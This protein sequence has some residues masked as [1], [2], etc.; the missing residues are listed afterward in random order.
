MKGDGKYSHHSNMKKSVL[1]F[2]IIILLMLCSSW[3]IKEKYCVKPAIFLW[4]AIMQ[5]DNRQYFI[6]GMYDDYGNGGYYCMNNNEKIP[7]SLI[8]RTP[9]SELSWHI[10][11]CEAGNQFLVKGSISSELSDLTEKEVILVEKWD[12]IA[13][14]C[15]SYEMENPYR[16]LFSPIFYLDKYDVETGAYYNVVTDIQ[17]IHYEEEVWTRYKSE[18]QCY[19][20]T[21]DIIDDKVHWYIKEE[22]MLKKI[23]IVGNTPEVHFN[24]VILSNLANSFL[25]KGT[26]DDTGETLAI[27]Q[28]Y[29]RYPIKRNGYISIYESQDYFEQRDIEEGVYI[30]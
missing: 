20:I 16:R 4:Q 28:W 6:V 19:I 23:N 27:E 9:L 18:L 22:D 8:G 13:P 3:Y 24:E 1:V 29:I 21:S 5:S 11:G 2:L 15:R 30:P 26:L 12:V 25:V 10:A 14:I 17:A 7:V